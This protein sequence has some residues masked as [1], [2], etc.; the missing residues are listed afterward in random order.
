MSCI[1]RKKGSFHDLVFTVDLTGY[2]KTESDIADI[3]FIVKPNSADPDT[4]IVFEKYLSGVPSGITFNSPDVINVSWDYNEYTGF[5]INKQY[6][7]GLFIKFDG[8]DK[9]DENVDTTFKL[10]IVPGFT[11]K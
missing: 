9:F 11:D 2:N 3:G 4:S 10:K 1:E 5:T 6:D 7:A 8:D